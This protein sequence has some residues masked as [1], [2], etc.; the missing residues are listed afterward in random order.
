MKSGVDMATAKLLSQFDA[1]PIE[2]PLA[3]SPSGNT[4]AT[5]KA[6][7]EEERKRTSVS[8]RSVG[9]DR[10][11]IWLVICGARSA[12]PNTYDD[13]TTGAPGET[14]AGGEEPDKGTS[15]PTSSDVGGPIVTASGND[16]GDDHV[17]GTHDG[18]TGDQGGL[19]S[20]CVNVEHSRD[21]GNEEDDTDDSGCKKRDGVA[22]QTDLLED[23]RGVVEDEV[24]PRP[25]LEAAYPERSDGYKHRGIT[26][27]KK[28]G[29]GRGQQSRF[30]IYF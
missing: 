1:A 30:E 3:R 19:T 2:T 12:G 25:L 20:P 13:P 21:G 18:S 29:V 8:S 27:R 14:E 10:H 5:C 17:A 6:R 7:Q 11:H 24:D 26:R 4:S 23:E 15:D 16:D 22:L 9:L 28:D